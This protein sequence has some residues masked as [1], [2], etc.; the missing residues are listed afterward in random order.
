MQMKNFFLILMI[1]FGM[2][3]P[4]YS[5]LFES[6]INSHAAAIAM[7]R[8]K[9]K[10]KRN[11]NLKKV[12]ALTLDQ[13]EITELQATLTANKLSA[14]IYDYVTFTATASGGIPPYT[15]YWWFDGD[16]SWTKQ[17]SNIYSRQ[18][19]RPVKQ[20]MYLVVADMKGQSTKE[21]SSS[22]QVTGAPRPQ[23]VENKPEKIREQDS[24][25]ETP[26]S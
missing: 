22:I 21:Y 5:D 15:Y 23:P 10:P 8:M 14:N 3:Y 13:P 4:C 26:R 7:F 24:S 2:T 9:P 18:I 25:T 1:F 6:S 17:K 11:S 20:T 19:T 12:Q 16:T